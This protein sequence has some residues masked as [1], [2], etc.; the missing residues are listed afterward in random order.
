MQAKMSLGGPVGYLTYK[1]TYSRMITDLGRTEEWYETCARA[2]NGLVEIGGLFGERE[3]EDLYSTMFNLRGL[4]SG[5]ALWQLGTETVGRIGAD[6]LCNCW[7][8]LCNNLDS[9]SFAFNQL[10]LGGGVGVNILPEHVYELPPVKFDMPI[11]RVDTP[12]CDFIVPDNREGWVELLDR[13]LQSFFHT[14]KPLSYST[15]CVRSAGT[16]IHTFGGTASGSEPLVIGLNQIVAILRSRVGEKLRPIDCADIMNIIGTIVVSGNVRRSSEIIIG[17]PHDLEFLN[18]KNWNK[19]TVPNWRSMCNMTV[20]TDSMRELLPDFWDPY[21]TDGECYGLINLNN[22][23]R[24]GRLVDGIDYRP[25]YGV[26]GCNPC[27]TGETLIAVADGRGA[28]AINKLDGDTPVYCLDDNDEVTVRMMR[29]PRVTG[30]KKIL[31]VT[32]DNGQSV[33][34]TENHKFLCSGGEYQQAS[35]LKP[36][37]GL[38]IMTRYVPEECVGVS[39]GDLY[40]YMSYGAYGRYYEHQEIARYHERVNSLTGKHVHHE[41]G[42]RLNNHPSNLMIKDATKHLQDHSRGE[43]NPRFRGVTNQQLLEKGIK[44]CKKLDR[45]FSHAEWVESSMTSSF[46]AFRLAEFGSWHSFSDT[47]ARLAGVEGGGVHIKTLRV[48]REMSQ[49]GYFV[50]LTEEHIEVLKTC[51]ACGKKFWIHHMRR[52]QACCGFS[53]ANTLRDRSQARQTLQKT[54]ESKQVVIRQQQLDTFTELKMNLGRIPQKK[55]WV[56]ECRRTGVSPEVSRKSSPFRSWK[57]LCEAATEHNH[58]IVSIT[59][60]G[61]EDV[62]NGTVDDFHNFFLGCFDEGVNQKGRHRWVA[63]NSPNCGESVLEHKEP[64]NLAEQFLPHITGVDQWRSIAVLLYKAA[65]TI[66]NYHYSDPVTEEVVRRN[67]RVGI[68]IS[69]WMA[70]PWSHDGTKLNAVYKTLEQADEHYSQLLGIPLSVKLT[71]IKPSG[72]VSLLPYGVTPGMH[73]AYSRYLI[74]RIRFSSNDPLIDI[75]RRHGYHVEPVLETDGTNNTRT[76]V[77]EFPMDMGSKA[78]TEDKVNVIDELE[79][80]KFLQTYWA[81]QSI[82]CTHYFKR[83][84]LPAIRDWLET[85]YKDS[86]KTCSFMHSKDHGFVQAPLERLTEPEYQRRC[87]QVSPITKITDDCEINMADSLECESGHCPVR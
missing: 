43:N 63:I 29:H 46:T 13:V 49:A 25:D 87:A 50:R 12:D 20:A 62:W 40:T 22:C 55:E 41:D 77:I 14:G 35:D 81:D 73:A 58:R 5:R 66:A 11:R 23:Q 72:T 60:D 74:R 27:V 2:C 28:V 80:Q 37:D 6:S 83:G 7:L 69:G 71:T 67:M 48:S 57:L 19:Q 78:I 54:V 39:R 8:V 33:R 36:G 31:K 26:E 24:F 32:F 45:R 9:F 21:E 59:E 64:C 15:Q 85:H 34:V 38:R 52:E 44:L 82:S 16:E 75:C 65:K 30:R 70:A 76:T 18:A 68:S 47:C 10:M 79:T 86:V 53:C 56:E 1:R 3:L 84:E 61:Y 42:N 17:H 4:V 51:E